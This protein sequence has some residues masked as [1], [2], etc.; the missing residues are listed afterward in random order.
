[1]TA[2]QLQQIDLACNPDSQR[3]LHSA[4]IVKLVEPFE[5]TRHQVCL[6]NFNTPQISRQSSAFCQVHMHTRLE[7]HHLSPDVQLVLVTEPIILSLANVLN[8]YDRLP[9]AVAIQHRDV[10]MSE[11]ERKHGL[12][13]VKRTVKLS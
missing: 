8:E 12:L 10:K 11:L 9:A 13:Q 7:P 2:R 5:E 4:G 3:P 6:N 1:V